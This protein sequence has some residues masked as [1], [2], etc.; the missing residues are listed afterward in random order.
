M[1]RILLRKEPRKQFQIYIRRVF[2][3]PPSPV[4]ANIPAIL[5]YDVPGTEDVGSP[6]KFRLNVGPA[7]QP[8]ARSMPVCDAGPTLTYHRVCCILCANTWHLINVIVPCF[9]TAALCWW[10]F[11][12]PAPDDTIHWPNSDVMLGHR[13]RRWTNS[14]PTKTL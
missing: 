9:L 1:S 3:P 4:M 6:T 11:N 5:A 10:R 8:I 7:V 12:I 13:L 2:L 14:I